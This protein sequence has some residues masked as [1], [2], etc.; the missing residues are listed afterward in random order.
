MMC[1]YVY[2]QFIHT[3]AYIYIY[4]VRRYACPIQYNMILV[5]PLVRASNVRRLVGIMI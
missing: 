5:S 2:I 3:Y 4:I 1:I